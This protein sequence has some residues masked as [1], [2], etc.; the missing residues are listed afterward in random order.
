MST[1]AL[2]QIAPAD[3][4]RTLARHILADGLEIVFDFEKSHGAW[5]HD[6]KTGR[7]YLDFLTFFGSNPIGYNHPKMQDREFQQMLV[8]VAQLKPSLSDVYSVEYAWFVDTFGRLARP[9][10]MKHAFFVEG[11]AL[12][13]ENAL[14]VAFDWKV[15]RNKAKGIAGEKGSKV[16]HFRE[17][18]HGRT[19]YTLSLTNTDPRKTDFYPK[20]PWPRIENPKLRFPVTREVEA[21]V[22]AAEERALDQI[23][24]A[25]EENPDDVAAIIIEP[26]QAE[27]GDNHFRPEFL[28]ALERA[29]RDNECLFIVDEVQTGV[30]LT[31]KMWAYEHFG[32]TPDLLAFGK[33][34]QV[35]GCL[36]GAR[37]DEEPE[38]VFK[39][40]SRI[41]STWGGGLTDMI[42]SGR[43]LE[44]IAEDHLAD[45]ARVVGER[46]LRGLEG[47]Q[48][49]L[50]GLMT[51]AR[52]RG[53]MIAF[54][55]PSA[56]ARD[57][58]HKRL[59][60]DGLLLL[61]CGVR[62]IRFRPPLNL[63]AAEADTALEIVRKSLGQL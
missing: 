50:G 40:P 51:N 17:A 42:R 35:G 62:S 58:A 21:D 11:G 23:R 52:G 54:D 20:F 15:R 22:R 30:A 19:G 55:L 5:V 34:V 63:T 46:L 57:K 29:A 12:G 25:F 43:Y 33:K 2:P 13:V 41:N 56:E 26:I 4:H 53:L 47:V 1:T 3:V 49:G 9:A 24:K 37:I 36:A 6:S 7:D 28:Q 48:A 8:R 60:E 38:N 45:N 59:I 18:F 32:L 31:G 61:T 14:K 10:A 27:G 39:V 44:V 16:I